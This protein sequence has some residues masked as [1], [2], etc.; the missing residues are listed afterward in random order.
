MALRGRGDP[1][2]ARGAEACSRQRACVMSRPSSDGGTRSSAPWMSNSPSCRAGEGRVSRDGGWLEKP[3]ERSRR[4][5]HAAGRGRGRSRCDG[6]GDAISSGEQGWE[7]TDVSNL[8]KMAP[9]F[10][11]RGAWAQQMNMGSGWFVASRSRVD[12]PEHGDVMLCRTEWI[13][14]ARHGEGYWLY[15]L[16][17]AKSEKPRGVQDPQPVRC[18]G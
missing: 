1:G 6:N 16:Y 17:G 2:G 9:V 13:A 3:T 7:P 15:V 18:P 4:L 14:A 8:H 10:N 5:R 11:I 12:A